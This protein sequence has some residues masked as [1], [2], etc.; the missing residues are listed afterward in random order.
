METIGIK[1]T[2]LRRQKA[3]SQEQLADL[4]KVIVRTIQRI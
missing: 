3:L 2:Q 4:A 1:I